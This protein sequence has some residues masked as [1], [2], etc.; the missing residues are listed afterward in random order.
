MPGIFGD[1]TIDTQM[2]GL[3]RVI[4]PRQAEVF[5]LFYLEGW[6]YPEIATHLAISTDVVGVWLHRARHRLRELL[7]DPKHE[8]SRHE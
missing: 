3:V 5:C 8:V 7:G 2:R 4:H 1:L 6:S